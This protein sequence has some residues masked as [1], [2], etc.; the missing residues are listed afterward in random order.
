MPAPRKTTTIRGPNDVH[1]TTENE[2]YLEPKTTTQ[3]TPTTHRILN[4]TS[5]DMIDMVIIV[6]LLYVIVAMPR[7]VDGN[8][9]RG[10]TTHQVCTDD[11]L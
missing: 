3:W 7:E 4:N 11:V 9:V 8:E 5:Q 2:P 10:K 6:S 1:T